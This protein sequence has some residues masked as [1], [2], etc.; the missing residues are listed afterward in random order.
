MFSWILTDN[1]KFPIL[2][3]NGTPLGVPP[4]RHRSRDGSQNGGMAWRTS[5][6]KKFTI[7]DPFRYQGSLGVDMCR[8]TSLGP[9]ILSSTHDRKK[10]AMAQLSFC[11]KKA[12]SSRRFLLSVKFVIHFPAIHKG[13][14]RPH[15]LRQASAIRRNRLLP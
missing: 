5:Q 13:H 3:P 8:P 15:N 1:L 2:S 7:T 4:C 9:L 6:N 12:A 10:V 11:K 14:D